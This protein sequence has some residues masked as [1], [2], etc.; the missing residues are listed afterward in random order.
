MFV[1]F[2]IAGLEKSANVRLSPPFDQLI[3]RNLG[4]TAN[5]AAFN[6]FNNL[7]QHLLPMRIYL[8]GFMGS[9]KSYLGRALAEQLGIGFLDLDDIIEQQVGISIADYFRLHGE[10]SFREIEATCLRATGSLHDHVIAT[11]GGTP[12]FFNNMEWMNENGTTI[13]L[14]AKLPFLVSRL[15]KEAAQRP[16]VASLP[17]QDLASFIE[18][19]IEERMPFYQQAQLE[20][21]V[22]ETGKNGI[23]TL[24]KYMKRFFSKKN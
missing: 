3:W 4:H 17:S 13:F 21:E 14:Q 19:K 10:K 22:P 20:F 24:A 11:G 5:F 15:E 1:I 6:R 12:C 16:L 9:G 8:I 2:F 7:L 23:D 18:Q